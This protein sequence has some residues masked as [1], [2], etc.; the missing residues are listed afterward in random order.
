VR[1]LS[2]GRPW[3]TTRATEPLEAGVKSRVESVAGSLEFRQVTEGTGWR[4]TKTW[5]TDPTR[6]AAAASFADGFATAETA[7]NAG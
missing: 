6:A 4:L 5:I 2:S 7:Y 1:G 3:T